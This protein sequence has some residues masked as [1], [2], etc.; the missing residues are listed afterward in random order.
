MTCPA[1]HQEGA[2]CFAQQRLVSMQTNVCTE[3]H[4]PEATH[5]VLLR[6]PDFFRRLSLPQ[7]STS[8]TPAWSGAQIG[9]DGA[10][11]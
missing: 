1:S 11:R 9:R 10:R 3:E 5:G 6:A 4:S 2:A 8:R 7:K